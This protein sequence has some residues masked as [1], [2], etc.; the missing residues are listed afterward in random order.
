MV[1]PVDPSVVGPLAASGIGVSGPFPAGDLSI[2]DLLSGVANQRAR[3]ALIGAGITS[4]N[5]NINGVIVNYP[6]SLAGEA[7]NLGDPAVP[8]LQSTFL[9]TN[10]K[11]STGN[12]F[13]YFQN[14]GGVLDP[15]DAKEHFV[16]TDVITALDSASTV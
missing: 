3:Q 6:I 13:V 15:T 5:V 7:F 16:H 12:L 1:S 8:I 10:Y 9:Y 14:D 2:F 11:L 4:I